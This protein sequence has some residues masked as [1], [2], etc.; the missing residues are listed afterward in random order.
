M[1]IDSWRTM[2]RCVSGPAG[3]EIRKPPLDQI[4]RPMTV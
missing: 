1:L 2:D 4:S 3:Q